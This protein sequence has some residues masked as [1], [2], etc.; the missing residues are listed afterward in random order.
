MDTLIDIIRQRHSRIKSASPRADI[1]LFNWG[2]KFVCYGDDADRVNEWLAGTGLCEYLE[3]SLEPWD[4]S[5]AEVSIPLA[6]MD[7]AV[8]LL[9]QHASVALVDQSDERGVPRFVTFLFLKKSGH[10]LEITEHVAAHLAM[11]E[12]LGINEPDPLADV[13]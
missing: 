3:L 12:K 4:W 1:G 11:A 5:L 6:S 13:F 9:L 7:K 10:S 8:H 2:G